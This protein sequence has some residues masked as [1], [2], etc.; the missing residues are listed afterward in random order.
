M[1]YSLGPE[2]HRLYYSWDGYQHLYDTFN[3]KVI[4]PED[5]NDIDRYTIGYFNLLF[6]IDGIFWYEYSKRIK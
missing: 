5:M 6:C 1:Y 4:N 3:M 2:K